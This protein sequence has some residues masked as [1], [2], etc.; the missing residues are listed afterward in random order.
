MALKSRQESS[1][2]NF[3]AFFIPKTLLFLLSAFFVS[4]KILAG[5]ERPVNS[6]RVVIAAQSIVHGTLKN[7][8]KRARP[9]RRSVPFSA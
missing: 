3:D 8:R 6:G 2:A 1:V 9:P 7:P 5:F 4:G